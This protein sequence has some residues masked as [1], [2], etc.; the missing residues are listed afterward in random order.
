MRSSGCCTTRSSG[1]ARRVCLT[2]I[3]MLR[4]VIT[5]SKVD[6]LAADS[7]LILVSYLL[8]YWALRTRSRRR[9]HRVERVADGV[10]L[11]ALLCMVLICGF[12]T[13]AITNS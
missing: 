5:T 1:S 3:G 12:I 9:M 2:V 6:P 4:V 7:L 10:F 8:S 11:A 13:Y